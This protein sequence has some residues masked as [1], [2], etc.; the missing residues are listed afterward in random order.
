[1]ISRVKNIP[2]L[3]HKNPPMTNMRPARAYA[4]ESL[5][6]CHIN[7]P[8]NTTATPIASHRTTT[9]KRPIYIS[10]HHGIVMLKTALATLFNIIAAAKYSMELA[11][12]SAMSFQVGSFIS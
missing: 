5:L 4:K 6:R 1:M 12:D 9:R 2:A 11:Q 3:K 7:R 8:R 10:Y